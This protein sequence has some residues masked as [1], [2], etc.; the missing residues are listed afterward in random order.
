[1]AV[2]PRAVW[3]RRKILDAAAEEFDLHGYTGATMAAIQ[4]RAGFT[5]GA[6]YFHFTS[7]AELAKAIF[8]AEEAWAST[9]AEP[10]G[11]AV[12][13]A[14][15]TSHDYAEALISDSAIRAGVRLAIEQGTFEDPAMTTYEPWIETT[16][17]MFQRAAEQGELR[18]GVDPGKAARGVVAAFVGTHVISQ[19][20]TRRADLHQRV[21]EFWDLV[22]PGLIAPEL[23]GV[24][25]T[26]GSRMRRA[27]AVAW[28]PDLKK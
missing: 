23:V 16:T 22:L 6:V 14:V 10:D 4:N 7:K 15:D 17:T 3:T 28:R 26:A 21:A 5:K 20:L 25:D 19:V 27:R 12:Q 8:S 18:T 1:M 2:Q 9:A 11:A 24:I 13:I